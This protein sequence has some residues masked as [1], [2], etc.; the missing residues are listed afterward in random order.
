MALAKIDD[1][2]TVSIVTDSSHFE[3]GEHRLDR[4]HL[5]VAGRDPLTQIQGDQ[6]NHLAR[7]GI[8]IGD[9]IASNSVL[10]TKQSVPHPITMVSAPAPPPKL[11]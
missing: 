8:E 6:V 3:T 11:S 2:V 1:R 5:T 9:H 7:E 10:K 4:I